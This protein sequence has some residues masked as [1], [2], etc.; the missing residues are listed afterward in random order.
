[1]YKKR[2]IRSKTGLEYAGRVLARKDYSE[3]ELRQKIAEHF[4][5]EEA[6][7]TISKLKGYGYLDDSRYREMFILSRV[8]NGYGPYRIQNDLGEKGLESDISDLDDICKKGDIDPRAILRENVV[9][10]LQRKKSGDPYK[11]KQSCIAHFYRKGHSI[12]DI[13]EIIEEEQQ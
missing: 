10:F 7:E 11:V 1:M 13:K 5:A 3:K 6:D 4:G 12:D 8:R 2:K 9:R